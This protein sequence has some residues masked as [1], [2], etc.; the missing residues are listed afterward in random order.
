MH[1]ME[2]LQCDTPRRT[3]DKMGKPVY[4]L[5]SQT[6]ANDQTYGRSNS[7]CQSK[8]A[9]SSSQTPS[10]NATVIN[11]FDKTEGND[12]SREVN[13]VYFFN[14]IHQFREVTVFSG[15]ATPKMICTF[16]AIRNVTF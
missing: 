5:T 13:C 15:T 4:H 1:K 2:T 8:S 9:R 6:P 7:S 14:C 16:S 11:T 12:C 3:F 10:S